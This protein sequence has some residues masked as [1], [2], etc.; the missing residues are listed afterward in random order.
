MD[1]AGNTT[2]R[3]NG[4]NSDTTTFAKFPPLDVHHIYLK[5]TY[6]Y[7]N[8]ISKV[9]LLFEATDGHHVWKGEGKNQ[10]SFLYIYYSLSSTSFSKWNENNLN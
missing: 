6:S 4:D 1:T 7:L 8:D 9:T 3:E 10:F 2:I 5:V